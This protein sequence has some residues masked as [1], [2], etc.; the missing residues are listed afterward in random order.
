MCVVACRAPHIGSIATYVGFAQ[1]VS[2]GATSI[3][4]L[5]LYPH[6]VCDYGIGSISPAWREV[7]TRPKENTLV[8]R[9]GEGVP[10]LDRDWNLWEF[11]KSVD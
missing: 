7:A 11:Q 8:E 9:V 3:D 1:A 10:Y 4:V 6:E 5:F 2:P